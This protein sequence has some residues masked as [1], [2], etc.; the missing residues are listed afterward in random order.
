[1]I[2]F[3][4]LN[5][6]VGDTWRGLQIAPEHRCEPY[7]RKE[8]NYPASIEAKIIARLGGRIYGPYSGTMFDNQGQTDIEHIVATSEAHDSGLCSRSSQEKRQFARDLDNLTLASVAVNRYQKKAY[9]AA[10]W[11]PE[12]NKCWYVNT[13]I[14][15]KRKYGLTMNRAEAVAIDNTLAQCESTAMRLIISNA[16]PVQEKTSGVQQASDL[17]GIN[18]LEKWDKNNN[19]KISCAEA[20]EYGI[21]PVTN[22]HPAYKYMRDGDKDGIVCE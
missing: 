5:H 17:S 2:F 6:A 1:M 14:E 18:P 20:R 9:D 3:L 21:A 16:A 15:V 10:E 13:V 19:G 22:D 8:Y 11:L 12:L 4:S 7:E